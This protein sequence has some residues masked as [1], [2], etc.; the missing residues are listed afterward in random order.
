MLVF[1]LVEVEI[2][3]GSQEGR[4]VDIIILLQSVAT[5]FRRF[6]IFRI[7]KCDKAI[8]LQNATVCYYKVR[9]VITKCDRLLL[10]RVAGITK[11][12]SY[13]K[14]RCNTSSCLFNL[15]YLI[16]FLIK[17]LEIGCLG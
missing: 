11:C 15:V 6:D 7:S 12:D 2:N 17:L 13:Y 5:Q 4:K 1:Y 10:Q 14:V 3:Q 8:L 16:I 9:Q